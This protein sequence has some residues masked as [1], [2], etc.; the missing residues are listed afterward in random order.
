MITRAHKQKQK[1][2]TKQRLLDD[3]KNNNSI[4]FFIIYV[5]SQQ[6]LGHLQT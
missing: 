3:D 5:P 2:Q 4:Q 1:N 6:L